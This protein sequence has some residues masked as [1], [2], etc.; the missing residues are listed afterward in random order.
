MKKI[1]AI[2]TLLA[3]SAS[4]C[5]NQ[6]IRPI[7]SGSFSSVTVTDTTTSGWFR[8]SN[9]GTAAIPAFSWS[10][11]ANSGFYR[12]GENNLGLSLGGSKTLDFLTTGLTVSDSLKAAYLQTGDG[13]ASNPGISFTGDANSGFYRIGEGNFGLSLDGT[14]EFD[15]L[16]TGLTV[17]DSI[18][19]AYVQT[20]S[21]D[22]SNPGFSFTTDGN[23]GVYRIGEDNIGIGVGG[24]KIADIASTGITVTGTLEGGTVTDGTASLTSGAITGLVSA[25]DGTASWSSNSLSGFTSISGTT[26]TDGT[27]SA[28][29]GAF[30]AVV[31]IT[32]GTASWSSNSLSGFTSISGTTLTDG[33]ASISSGAFTGVASIT[34]GTASWSGS[35][36]SGFTDITATDSITGGYLISGSGS[37]ANPAIHFSTDGNS[38]FYRSAEDAISISLGGSQ[39]YDFTASAANLL[40]QNLTWNNGAD[41]QND[42]ADTLEITETVVKITGQPII[43]NDTWF[44]AFSEAGS[45]LNAFK[46]DTGGYLNFG[47]TAKISSLWLD[48]DTGAA[49][50]VNLPVT[51]DASNGTEESIRLTIDDDEFI[52]FY[53]ESDGAGSIQN[54]RIEISHDLVPA[55]SDGAGLGTSSLMFSD[56]FLASG[57]VVNFDNGDVTITHSA[58]QLDFA[59]ATNEYNFDNN[60]EATGTIFSTNANAGAILNEAASATNP[61]IVPD[62]ADNDNGLGLA[63]TDELS[64]IAGGTE[65]ARFVST[66][67][68]FK[69]GMEVNVTTVNAATYDLL[70]TDYIL[71][72]T[73]TGTGAVTSITLPSAQVVSGRVIVIKDAGG[74]ANTNNITVDTEGAE[75][76][77]GNATYVLDAD[78]E[79]V[80]L[81]SDGS[82]WFA[83]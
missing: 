24:S 45:Q 41:I 17:T 10:D 57:S 35:S 3:V 70:A 69:G 58:N 50:I 14:K 42:D 66:H 56:L 6:V 80:T 53:A 18:K 65:S 64:A 38:G 2:L 60:I 12:I 75:T 15:F 55:S 28:S 72:V 48:D 20:G 47:V 29:S 59:G 68:E 46:I 37:A 34:D 39:T 49:T 40:D 44:Q 8:A 31:S 23:S 27:F 63:T 32:D 19:G 16:T 26:I 77:D 51:S 1:F 33:T 78:Y 43:P 9:D 5:F 25:T 83:I 74:N 61:T 36:L 7:R 73:Y 52:K 54:Q 81:Y 79:S 62:R 67:T 30:T 71:N 4:L 11:D 76:I 13:D 21:G 22:A 82:N